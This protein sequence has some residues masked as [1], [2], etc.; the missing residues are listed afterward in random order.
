LRTD[1]ISF[2]IYPESLY[3]EIR[4]KFYS[5][6]LSVNLSDRSS[7]ALNSADPV[8]PEDSEQKV[9]PILLLSENALRYVI[10]QMRYG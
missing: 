3:E 10:S 7:K 2:R 4:F 8:N 9:L 1:K 6:E 5:G